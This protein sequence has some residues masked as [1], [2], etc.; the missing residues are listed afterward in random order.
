MMEPGASTPSSITVRIQNQ[1][2]TAG[3]AYTVNSLA[4]DVIGTR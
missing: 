3:Q 4:L 1:C 2:V